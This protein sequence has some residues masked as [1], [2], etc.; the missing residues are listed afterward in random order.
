MKNCKYCQESI[1][2][3]AIKCRYCGK[4]LNSPDPGPHAV[5]ISWVLSRPLMQALHQ[6]QAVYAP[7]LGS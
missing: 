7:I 1:Q 6:L 5:R 2:D 4:F 3:D